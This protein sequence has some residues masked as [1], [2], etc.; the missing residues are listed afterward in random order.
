MMVQ[1]PDHGVDVLVRIR[2][3]MPELQPAAQRVAGLVLSDPAGAAQL[4]IGVLA[5][6]A[7]T[8]VATVMRFCRAVG[9]N[10]YPQLRLALA[11]AAA[12]ENALISQREPATG[13]IDPDDSLREIVD[14]IAFNESRAISETADNLDLDALERCIQLLTA[15]RRIDIFGIGASGIVAHD[16]HQKLHRIG[17]M[18]FV[19]T[20]PHAA[21]TAAALLTPADVALGISHSGSTQDTVEPLQLAVE[22]GAKTI[23]ITNFSGSKLAVAADEVLST[24]VRETPFRS[25]ATASRIAQLAVVDFLFVGVAQRSYVEAN[26]AL[27]STFKAIHHRR[28]STTRRRPS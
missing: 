11:G 9:E 19:W 12:R 27:S 23:A 17:L 7:E 25:G 13:D 2:D 6:R 5:E 24:A 15:A 3:V 16:L 18:A 8:S 10:S 1:A 4:T 21:L 22:C 26:L 20:D 14:K 28:S